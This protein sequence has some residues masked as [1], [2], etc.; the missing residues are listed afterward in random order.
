MSSLMSAITARTPKNRTPIKPAGEEMH[1]QQHHATTAKWLDEARW[2]GFQQMGSKTA[3][4]KATHSIAVGQATPSKTPVS[5]STQKMN[6]LPS[7]EFRFRF[8]SPIAGLSPKSNQILQGDDVKDTIA[9]GRPLF[10]ADEFSAPA[11][12]SPRKMAVPKGKSSRFSD[13]HMA[14]FKKMD[15][16][17]N[18]PSAFRTDPNRFKPVNTLLKKSPSKMDLGAPEPARIGPNK[19]KRTQSKMNVSEPTP[20]PPVSK[21]VATPLKRAQSKIDLTQ[22]NSTYIR[23][24]S[25]LRLVPPSRHGL[26][27]SRDGDAPAKRVKRTET[28]DAATTRPVLGELPVETPKSKIPAR[29]LPRRNVM[30]RLMTPTKSSIMRSQSVKTLKTTSML[31]SLLKSPSA[32]A[33]FSPTNIGQAMKDGMQEGFRKT[34]NSLHRVRSIL[35]TPSRKFSEDP[36]KVAAG[37][38]M[39]P[40]LGLDIARPLPQVPVTA[41]VKKHVNFTTSTLERAGETEFGKS[42]SPVKLRAGSEMPSGAVIYPKLQSGVDYPSLPEDQE[43]GSP[44]RRLTFGGATDNNPANGQFNFKSDKPINFGP[45]TKGTI[46]MV[47]KSDAS[48][49]VG[50]KKR[51]LDTFEETSDKEN[52]KPVDEGRSPAKKARTTTMEPPRTP[53]STSKL[54]RRT[55]G[56]GGSISKSRLAFLATPKRSKA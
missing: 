40:P 46:R 9:G 20:K 29:P 51:K 25:T 26:P 23:P 10:G 22:P 6:I 18:H 30:S 39:S 11:D 38:H 32:K 1:P 8:R 49:L 4:P 34:S 37:T 2:L 27:E 54:P 21:L 47:R 13:V 56:R 28:D 19:L 55:P 12:V 17:A 33:L 42:P 44:T 31:P 14:E 48:S 5:V 43:I 36:E 53:A 45:A 41:P 3:P 24:S 16:I 15:S 52:N 7:P 35:R 50:D